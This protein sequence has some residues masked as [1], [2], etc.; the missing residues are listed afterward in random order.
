MEYKKEVKRDD[1]VF[2]THSLLA[3]VPI[4]SYTASDTLMV[5]PATANVTV[6]LHFT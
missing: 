2:N 5:L 6:Y 1:W 4:T 3:G